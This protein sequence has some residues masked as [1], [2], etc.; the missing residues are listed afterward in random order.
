[1][2]HLITVN[3][4][5]SQLI[6]SIRARIDA[7][8]P[9]RSVQAWV[10]CPC[11]GAPA[12]LYVNDSEMLMYG[13]PLCRCQNC[14]ND[15]VAVFHVKAPHSSQGRARSQPQTQPTRPHYPIHE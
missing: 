3:H 7:L 15:I 6:A 4:I 10:Q 12:P 14:G 2:F 9:L 8:V 5:A 1:M 11:C 13:E